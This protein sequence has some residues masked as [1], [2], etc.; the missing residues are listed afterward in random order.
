MANSPM[1]VGT[2]ITII[3]TL[4]FA[5][6]AEAQTAAKR[7]A[8]AK[9]TTTKPAPARPSQVFAPVKDDPRLPRV[10]LIG[11]SISMGY[12]LPV[13]ELLKGRANVH[14]PPENC[15]P[16]TR[17]VENLEAW[18]GTGSW[19][20]IHFNFGLHDL[21][22]V[23]DKHQV[24][25]EDYAKNLRAIVKRLKK[26][27]ARLIWCSTTPVPAGGV[28]PLRRNEDVI[29]YNAVARKVMEDE[30]IPINDLYAFA[31]PRI[32][33]IQRPVNVHFHERGS[34]VL[35]GRV[36]EVIRQVLDGKEIGAESKPARD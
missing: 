29:A 33:T 24:S 3:G 8:L 27:E 10:L 20:V 12:T 22:F 36:A 25:P 35:A 18:L 16:T 13:R 23:D 14:R 5:G 28:R 19:D 9:T 7:P 30:R 1:R 15:G 31:L 4:W 34:R 6:L 32:K 17:G 2:T 21:K 11:D 26:T